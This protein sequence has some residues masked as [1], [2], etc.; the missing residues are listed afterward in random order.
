M[1]VFFFFNHRAIFCTD[2]LLKQYHCF[3]E[4]QRFVEEACDN[5]SLALLTVRGKRRMDAGLQ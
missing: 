1:V 3:E 5:F 4:G 2:F